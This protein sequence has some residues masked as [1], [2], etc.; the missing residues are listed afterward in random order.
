MSF[1]FNDA[2]NDAQQ[3]ATSPTVEFSSA[4]ATHTKVSN[5]TSSRR[6]FFKTTVGAAVAGF[7]TT[8]GVE[9][10]APRRV[11]A[12][13]A[14]TPDAALQELMDGNRRFSTGSLTSCDHDLAILK[15]HTV[16]KQRCCHAPT[17]ASPSS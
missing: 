12:Q 3:N 15:A 9:C 6:S 11:L 16:D 10:L 17:R 2:S 14:L 8:A 13:T 1:L 5:E 7:V 4:D